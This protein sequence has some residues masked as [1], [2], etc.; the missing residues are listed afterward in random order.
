M[1]RAVALDFKRTDVESL[2]ERELAVSFING[3][4]R[5]S[6]QDEMVKLLRRKSQ[7]VVAF[8][9]CAHLG[10]IPGLANI[11]DRR[12]IFDAVYLEAPSVNNPE[13]V[14]P[15]EERGLHII[16]LIKDTLTY[17]QE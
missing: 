9:S 2:S 13:K 7:L 17:A 11:T 16:I 4:V 10:G 1:R 12:S 14:M 3:A 6:E 5:S 8:G 15:K